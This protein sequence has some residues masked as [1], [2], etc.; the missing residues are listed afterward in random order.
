MTSN[1][2]KSKTVSEDITSKSEAT[3]GSVGDNSYK[4]EHAVEENRSIPEGELRC[5]NCSH[6]EDISNSTENLKIHQKPKSTS[7]D[8]ER[9]T[10]QPMKKKKEVW[11]RQWE[12]EVAKKQG[13]ERVFHQDCTKHAFSPNT[14]AELGNIEVKNKGGA[15]VNKIN[16][17]NLVLVS[18]VGGTMEP[19]NKN[20]IPSDKVKQD[21]TMQ[22]TEEIYADQEDQAKITRPDK[23]PIRGGKKVAWKNTQKELI[24]CLGRVAPMKT[25]EGTEKEAFKNT[26]LECSG[27]DALKHLF[28]L[29]KRMQNQLASLNAFIKGQ[30]AQSSPHMEC[31]NLQASSTSNPSS[32]L[33]MVLA[34][35]STSRPESIGTEG[36]RKPIPRLG[37]PPFHVGVGNEEGLNLG[38]FIPSSSCAFRPY[39]QGS[40][41]RGFNSVQP[42]AIA[43]REVI[44]ANSNTMTPQLHGLYFN[45]RPNLLAQNFMP[46]SVQT[47]QTPP[48]S[49][50]ATRISPLANVETEA[51]PQL[52]LGGRFLLSNDNVILKNNVSHDTDNTK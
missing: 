12:V 51:R 26:T 34:S 47:L 10:Q 29:E 50:S 27:S 43:H 13:K 31:N 32:N 36:P 15:T 23:L 6:N 42:S 16:I 33:Q 24:E 8:E 28:D 11:R 44:N 46:M 18:E 35:G 17:E 25:T 41:S 19:M 14:S 37:I 21:A 3:K 49:L 48:F 38:R 20:Y 2:R 7:A 9:E 4:L 5:P 30:N 39:H 22:Q 40:S 1:N 45:E 52:L